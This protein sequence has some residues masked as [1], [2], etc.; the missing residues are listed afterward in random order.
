MISP[1]NLRG[2]LLNITCSILSNNDT[3]SL[4]QPTKAANT[5][6]A[7]LC[8][9]IMSQFPIV[10]EHHDDISAAERHLFTLVNGGWA[11][12]LVRPAGKGWQVI[13]NG[14]RGFQATHAKT[15]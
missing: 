4:Q 11:A 12:K 5:G 9:V 10:H 3:F 7:P 8:E 1:A 15:A 13:I 14:F 2:F 6:N